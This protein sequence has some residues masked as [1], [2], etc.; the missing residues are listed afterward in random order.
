MFPRIPQWRNLNPSCDPSVCGAVRT[1]VTQEASHPGR[2]SQWSHWSPAVLCTGSV[3]FGPFSLV[4][5]GWFHFWI[6]KFDPCSLRKTSKNP[7]DCRLSH[8]RTSACL[9]W[10][11]HTLKTR[12]MYS[13]IKFTNKMVDSNDVTSKNQ[14]PFSQSNPHSFSKTRWN[15]MS[16][17]PAFKIFLPKIL[18][19]STP[20]LWYQSSFIKYIYQVYPHIFD[21]S[22]SYLVVKFPHTPW[23]SNMAIENPC[24]R[25]PWRFRWQIIKL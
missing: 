9:C 5:M 2:S 21:A 12:E 11:V 7:S 1:H 14:W 24:G 19:G 3:W 13:N 25:S 20:K 16:L 23:E 10:S 18:L 6:P 15:Q 17:I 4:F 22:T 8:F